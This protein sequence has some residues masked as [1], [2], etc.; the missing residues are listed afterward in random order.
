MEM[1]TRDVRHIRPGP[2][3]AGGV[4]LL[5]GTAM[6]LDSAGLA[7]VHIWRSIGPLVLITFGA[8]IMSCGARG[9]EAR[10]HPRRRATPTSGI[11]LIGVGLWLLASQNHLFGL[12]FHTSWPLLIVLSGVITVI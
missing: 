6:F 9:G 4:L 5:A 7:H 3:V 8:S 1:P 10:P 12:D 11:W 2:L